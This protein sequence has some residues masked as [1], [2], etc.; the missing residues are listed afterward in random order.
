MRRS[1]FLKRMVLPGLE[2]AKWLASKF[3]TS[4]IEEKVT[5]EWLIGKGEETRPVIIEIL[6]ARG[7]AGRR[8]LEKQ[9]EQFREFFC[10][11]LVWSDALKRMVSVEEL[12]TIME[13]MGYE[14]NPTTR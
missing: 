14:S 1:D 3:G 6:N 8:W 9:A 2:R 13:K 10:G 11:R 7:E 12:K 5:A 4:A